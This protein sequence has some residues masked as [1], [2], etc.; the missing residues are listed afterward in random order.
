MSGLPPDGRILIQQNDGIVTIFDSY[1]D[2]EFV[3][4]DPSGANAAAKAQKA[5]YDCEALNAEQKCFA[6]F[7]SGYFYAHGSVG[8]APPV[9]WQEPGVLGGSNV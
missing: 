9:R 8:Q 6:H 4:F 1:T 7:W 2:E 3:R 5:I